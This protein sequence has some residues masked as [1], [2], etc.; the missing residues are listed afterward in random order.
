MTEDKNNN[1]PQSA[2]PS[3]EAEHEAKAAEKGYHRSVKRRN[4]QM[5]RSNKPTTAGGIKSMTTEDGT[6][7]E[8]SGLASTTA[9]HSMLED[10][11]GAVADTLAGYIEGQDNTM[12]GP[13]PLWLS[14]FQEADLRNAAVIAL[15]TCMDAIGKDWPL[16]SI[17]KHAG[18][19]LNTHQFHAKLRSTNRQG[20]RLSAD[21]D[22][23]SKDVFSNYDDR[24]AYAIK[25][26]EEAGHKWDG[27]SED[28]VISC[29]SMLVNAVLEACD[30]FHIITMQEMVS[31]PGEKAKYVKVRYLALT[32]EAEQELEET[33]ELLDG[34]A[35]M[36]PPMLTKPNRWGEDAYGPYKDPALAK[37]VPLVKHMGPDQKA[38]IKAAIADGSLADCL[39]AINLLQEVPYEVNRTV[40]DAVAW[41]LDDKRHEQLASFPTLTKIPNLKLLSRESFDKLPEK[42]KAVYETFATYV[43]DRTDILKSNREA[44]A[45]RL[46]IKRHVA[47]ARD[48]MAFLLFFLPHQFDTR[49]RVYHTSDFGHHNSDYLRGMFLFRNKTKVAGNEAFLYMQLANCWGNEIVTADGKTTSSDKASYDDRIAWVQANHAKIL[50]A[51]KDFKAGFP[52][53]RQADNAFQF[54]AACVEYA[55][56]HEQ[57]PDYVSG[58]PI[59][60]DATNSGIQHYAA[61]GRNVPDGELVN[62]VPQDEPND[63]YERCL[64]EV[65]ELIEADIIRLEAMDLG[66]PANDNEEPDAETVKNRRKLTAARQ[67]RDY[68]IKRK[69]VKRNC[70]TWAY[71]SR[72]Y[73]FAEQ[74]RTDWMDVITKDIRVANSNLK[75]GE[76]RQEHPFGADKGFF[77][78]HYLGGINEQAIGRVVKSAQKGM[79]FF[80]KCAAALAAEG[81]H[82]K[83]VTPVGFPMQQYYRTQTVK[84]Q[85]VWLFDRETKVMDKK[86]R[87]SLRQYQDEVKLKKSSNASSPNI[88]HSMDAAHLILTVLTCKDN[89]VTDLMVVHDSFSTTIGNAEVMKNAVRAAFV[90]LYTDYCLYSRLLEQVREQLDDP[91]NADLPEVPEPGELDLA[92]VLMSDYFFM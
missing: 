24:R 37:L 36:F 56:F 18:L 89:G 39:E 44:V 76:E 73:G 57:G 47:E 13:K 92:A 87:A 84:R 78:S 3:H 31:V 10:V 50:M 2:L 65:N 41:V 69:H 48:L 8:R 21:L 59:G 45:N 34:L 29:G 90:E 77:A 9:G 62:L 86:S 1:Q 27:W 72:R 82:L 40:V 19:A 4:Q 52:F 46:N 11:A 16:N 12:G 88:I 54:L 55:N 26:A 6:V 85:K 70:M 53:W 35:P 60:L 67:F 23:R 74:L 5:K 58:L 30:K 7:L 68:G 63:L 51:G 79:E 61:A 42:E 15:T 66:E 64:R 75:P 43:K 14:H 83:F 33:N 91:D 32:P 25:K 28:V 22:E 38:A 20:R 80:Q 49:G 81:K 71:S 17:W